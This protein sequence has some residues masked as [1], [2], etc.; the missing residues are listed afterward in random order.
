MECSCLRALLFFL[1]EAFRA[2]MML[3]GAMPKSAPTFNVSHA[4]GRLADPDESDRVFTS[5]GCHL[6]FSISAKTS[7]ATRI[8]SNAAGMPQ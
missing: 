6:P 2:T 1:V 8:A 4:T 5:G 3:S 7:L